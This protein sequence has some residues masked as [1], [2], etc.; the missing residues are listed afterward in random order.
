M[1]YGTSRLIDL[2]RSHE[3]TPQEKEETV[4]ETRLDEDQ[5]ELLEPIPLAKSNVNFCILILI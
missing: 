1:D 3:N 4:D 5:K 2:I